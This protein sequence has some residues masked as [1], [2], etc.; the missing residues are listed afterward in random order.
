VEKVC[1]E[2]IP[3]GVVPGDDYVFVKWKGYEVSLGV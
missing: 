3:E 2:C 1:L